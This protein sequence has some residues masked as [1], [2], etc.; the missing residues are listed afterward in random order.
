[1]AEGIEIHHKGTCRSGGGGHCNCRP[2]F[3]ASVWS[4]R[5]GKKVKKT[6]PSKAAAKAWRHDA[7]VARE[8]GELA[9]PAKRKLSE[10]AEAW[11]DGAR[12]GTVHNRS[13]DPYKPSA[14]RSY[15]K[16]LRLRVLP[17]FGNVKLSELRRIDL[18]DFVDGLVA[19]GLSPSTIDSALNPVRAIYRYAIARNEISD[20]LN[21]TR[22]LETPAIRSKPKRIADPEEAERLLGALREDD[23]PVWAT[24]LYAGLRRGELR[25]LRWGDVDLAE[26][27]IRVER[28]WDDLEGA[29]ELKSKAGRRRVPIA[30][31]LRDF[32][33]AYKLRSGRSEG[34]VFGQDGE[35]PF[36][37]GKLT[38]RADDD[39]GDAGL[40]RITLHAC[41]HTFAS[42]MIA[43]G[44]NAK[45]LSTYMGH[46]TIAITLD[47]YGHLM[48]GNESE[49]ADLLDAYLEA[50]R[51][52]ADDAARSSTLMPEAMPP[53][54]PL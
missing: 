9:T 8:R 16:A 25:A 23:R 49:A 2:S 26:G 24:A 14:I 33:I 54:S 30:A 39:W 28:G 11:L 47:L 37:P 19:D 17:V 48:P 51:R 4:P 52:R 36:N 46:A 20:G 13:G 29:I 3:R 27:L 15:E 1:M 53:A 6:F 38:E 40:E 43:A 35:T 7:M 18:Q 34:L 41:R 50:Q 44:V 31:V 5:E 21:P 45:A 10:A 12:A 32:L 22:N 42:Y